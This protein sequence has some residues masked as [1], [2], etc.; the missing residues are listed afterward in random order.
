MRYPSTRVAVNVNGTD[1]CIPWVGIPRNP[2]GNSVA[3]LDCCAL[4]VAGPGG[5]TGT[6][7]I[8]CTG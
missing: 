4:K 7:K 6:W 3:I 8:P 5:P 2:T 1:V